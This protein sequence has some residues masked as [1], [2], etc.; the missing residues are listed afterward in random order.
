MID[1]MCKLCRYDAVPMEACSFHAH[2]RQLETVTG[3]IKNRWLY[4]FTERNEIDK[5]NKGWRYRINIG[6]EVLT[7]V[8]MKSYVF[9]DITPCIMLKG[10]RQFKG[11]CRLHFQGWRISQAR[12]QQ[13]L[14][15]SWWFLAWLIILPWSR[16][17]HVPPRRRLAFNGLH[18]VVPQ[19]DR[20][21]QKK[22]FPI[23]FQRAVSICL[24]T[25]LPF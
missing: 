6:S 11:T 17:W 24:Y 23:E 14:P 3:R 5:G 21:L 7:A 13:L 8:V 25:G 16:K 18:G 9:W 15:A 4:C 2:R 22:L 20:T 19:E 12:N 1:F 10:N